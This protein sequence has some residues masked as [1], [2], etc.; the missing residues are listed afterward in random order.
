MRRK[1]KKEMKKKQRLLYLRT[2][3]TMWVSDWCLW[4]DEERRA[5]TSAASGILQ[6]CDMNVKYR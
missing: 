5:S 4:K 6:L 2:A 3:S 1:E